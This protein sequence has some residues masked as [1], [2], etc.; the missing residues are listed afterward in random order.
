MKKPKR[1]LLLIAVLAFSSC[2]SDISSKGEQNKQ[3]VKKMVEIINS[4]D[5]D[6]L[7]EVIA[8]DLVRHS[9]ATPDANVKSLDDMKAFLKTDNKAIP[10]SVITVEK[11]ISEGDM[12]AGRFTYEGTQKGAMGPFPPTNKRV[13][14]PYLAFLRIEKGKVAEMWVEWDNVAILTQ[15]GHFPPGKESD[16]GNGKQDPGPAKKDS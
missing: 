12:V 5:Y 1:L 11:L 16:S 9:A 4:R 3:V 10:D 14:L 15:L 7:G 13:K 6:K 8:D 2:G